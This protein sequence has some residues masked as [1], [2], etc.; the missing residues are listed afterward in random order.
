MVKFRTCYWYGNY[1]WLFQG[2]YKPTLGIFWELYSRHRV[3]DLIL[4]ANLWVTLI[5]LLFNVFTCLVCFYANDL[6]NDEYMWKLVTKMFCLMIDCLCGMKIQDM[7]VR[8]PAWWTHYDLDHLYT[9]SLY[10]L[11]FE[12][13][14]V[15]NDPLTLEWRVRTRS[16][17]RVGLDGVAGMTHSW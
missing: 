5:A 7:D 15:L 17:A 11:R 4:S 13:S 3:L 10:I 2:H 14:I 16:V 8:W 1:I 12:R 9:W 6:W